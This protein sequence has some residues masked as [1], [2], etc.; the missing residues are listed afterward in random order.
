M[1]KRFE[2]ISAVF[3]SLVLLLCACLLGSCGRS[4]AGSDK[5]YTASTVRIAYGFAFLSS[6]M[7]IMEIRGILQKYLPEGVSVE[8]SNLLNFNNIR[9]AMV[10]GSVDIGAMNNISII[11]AL[12]NDLPLLILSSG[13]GVSAKM[14]S[15]N[16]EIKSL[17]DIGGSHKIALSNLGGMYHFSLMLQSK[18]LYGDS[19]KYSNNLVVMPYAEMMASISAKT[20]DCA[21]LT[22]PYIQ[23]VEESGEYPEILDLT[24]ILTKYKMGDVIVANKDFHEKNPLLIEAM[25]NA[26]AE[27]MDYMNNQPQEAS[28]LLADFYGTGED[29]ASLEALI[30]MLPPSMELSESSYDSLA[31]FMYEIDMLPAPPKKFSELPNYETIPKVA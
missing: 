14:F 2:K 21:V 9:E 26:V 7:H 31:S 30:K 8:Y 20:V 16:E 29:P 10:S 27:A 4:Q 24:P 13:V 25:N 28:V 18:E 11:S 3:L 15:V 17:D 19:Q 23:Q 5:G 22:S 6:A 12:E 1:C